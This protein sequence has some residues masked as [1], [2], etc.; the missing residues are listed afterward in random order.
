MGVSSVCEDIIKFLIYQSNDLTFQGFSQSF[1]FLSIEE[2]SR[3]SI[4]VLQNMHFGR[5]RAGIY[6]TNSILGVF[7]HKINSSE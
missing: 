3:V 5:F 1:F 2:F 4:T 7:N 6:D